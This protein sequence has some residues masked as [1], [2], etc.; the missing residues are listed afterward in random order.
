[1]S[2]TPDEIEASL[3]VPDVIAE[4]AGRHRILQEMERGDWPNQRD[5]LPPD[6]PW[7]EATN[8]I[9]QSLLHR[10]HAGLE[11]GMALE[12]VLS[13]LATRAWFEGGIEGYAR[14]QREARRERLTE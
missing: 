5:V 9:L 1:M 14:G 4:L 6:P 2:Q 8:P 11:A 3:H 12:D 13:R 10:A 7:P